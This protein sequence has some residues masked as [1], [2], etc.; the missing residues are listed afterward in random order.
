LLHYDKELANGQR[1]VKHLPTGKVWQTIKD[2]AKEFG[3]NPK[4]MSRRC[5]VGE[6][7]AFLNE[8]YGHKKKAR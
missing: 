3:V 5:E 2:A 6:T 4:T 7:F 8:R 1:R